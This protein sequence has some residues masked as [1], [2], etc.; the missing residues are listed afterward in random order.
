[1]TH[2][3]CV[4]AFDLGAGS[5]RAF[6]GAVTPDTIRLDE[7]HRFQYQPRQHDRHLRWDMARLVD[8]LGEG[9]RRSDAMA[10]AAGLRLTSAGVD[11][12]GV[13]YGLLDE[14]GTLIDEPC[15]YRDA[16]TDGLM[17]DVFAQLAP[18]SAIFAVTG[19]QFLPINTIYQLV[20][21][22]REGWPVRAAR[23]L[24]MPDLCHHWLC[25]SMS[26]EITNAST[27]QLL[28][29]RSRQWSDD[30]I[31]AIDLPAVM[32]DLV[33]A[34]ADLGALRPEHARQLAS[35]AIRIVAPAT[36]DTASA[37]AGTPLHPGW[38][39]ISS[40]TWSL[41]GVE[42]ATPLIDDRVAAANFTNE[43]GVF[44][45]VRFL[46]NVMGLWIL[47]SCRR[48]WEAAGRDAELA[49]LLAASAA[50]PGPAGFIAPDAPRFFHPASMTREVLS[51]LR[52]SG[53][54]ADDTP[55][56]IA[57]V[58]LDSLACR[59]AD[60]VDEIEAL[61]GQPI[62]GIHIVGGGSRNDYLN[63]AT[64]NACGRPVLAG[65]VEATAAGNIVVQAIADGAIIDLADGRRRIAASTV[66]RRFDPRDIAAWRNA[67]DRYREVLS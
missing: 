38:A 24:M 7:A 5:G 27:T 16:R 66:L 46:K 50:L 21:H 1:M 37:F 45:T 23:L 47:E 35:G 40:G 59:Y 11:T 17:E 6:L 44:G 67:R 14:S 57:R 18:R 65:P 8:G 34:G 43:A 2:P 4:A 31:D 42:R 12:W 30:L 64:A 62:G 54:A 61:T 32:P 41:V 9:L 15:C 19:L 26:S 3:V 10:Q 39:C 29:A 20:A 60:V 56:A 25:G 49:P 22:L 33:D 58:V 48:E 52:E 63:Q 55:A 36:H 28:D 51:A 53:Q 13:D